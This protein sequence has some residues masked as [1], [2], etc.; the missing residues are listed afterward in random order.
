MTGVA[1][2]VALVLAIPPAARATP[3]AEDVFRSVDGPDESQS[4][5]NMSVLPWIC[6]GIALVLICVVISKRQSG[7]SRKTLNSMNK[8]LHEVQKGT[9]LRSLHI[10][11]LK[12]AATALNCDSPL[13]LLLCPSLMAALPKNIGIGKKSLDRRALAILVK[14]V[15]EETP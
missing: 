7:T 10:K 2:F 13:T 1:I 8:L 14:Q 4:S 15:Q 6:G 3:T 11:Q 5:G 9:P 12:L